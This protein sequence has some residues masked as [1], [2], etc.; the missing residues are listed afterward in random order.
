[1]KEG[2][3][4]PHGPLP[5]CQEE[6][7]GARLKPG[8]GNL[9]QVSHTSGRATATGALTYLLPESTHEQEASVKGRSG[10]QTQALQD[11]LRA[12]QAI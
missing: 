11:R 6:P 9:S 7:R 5:K 10:T 3:R 1:M 4:D 8:T 2:H 12:F